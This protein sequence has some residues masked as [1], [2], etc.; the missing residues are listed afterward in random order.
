MTPGQ[1]GPGVRRVVVWGTC[2]TGK[3]RVRILLQGLRENGVEVVECRH[4]LWNGI[5]D[6]SQIKGLS[7]WLRLASRLLLAYPRLILRYLRLPDHDWILVG[8]P[9]IVDLLVIRPFAWI[10]RKPIAMDWFLS[11]YDTIVLDRRL[12]SRTS[13]PASL[14]YFA[15]WICV[16]AADI[17]FMDTATHAQRMSRLFNIPANRCGHVWVGVEASNFDLS[18]HST[19]KRQAGV[20]RV[21]FYGQF[22]PLHGLETIIEAAGLLKNEPVDW[23]VIGT[24]QEAARIDGQLEKLQLPRVRRTRWVAYEALASELQHADVCLGIFGTSDK[25]ASVIPNKVFQ[26]LAAGRPLITRASP[27][28]NEL[29]TE[30]APDVALVTA[31]NARELADAVMAWS[32]HPPP[33][34]QDEAR[35]RRLTQFLP[36]AVGQ[37]CLHLLEPQTPPCT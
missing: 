18:E 5:E 11:A 16:R 3:P 4:S 13:L 22:I 20:T 12:C 19:P 24:G 1:N 31:G 29:L 30:P 36:K 8:Y 17:A 28:I 27:A 37:Q 7:A 15:E 35:S 34:L 26:I 14:I 32:R 23:I 33:L 2:D 10:R 25:A 6:K 21:L 9:A